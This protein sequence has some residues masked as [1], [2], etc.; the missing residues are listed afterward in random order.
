MGMEVPGMMPLGRPNDVGYGYPS[1]NLSTD[2]F[3]L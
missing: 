1:W 3:N 2:D